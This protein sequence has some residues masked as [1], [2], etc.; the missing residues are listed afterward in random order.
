MKILDEQ[1]RFENKKEAYEFAY[2]IIMTHTVKHNENIEDKCDL[3]W[4]YK[5]VDDLCPLSLKM[6]LESAE[7]DDETNLKLSKIHHNI[8]IHEFY[9]PEERDLKY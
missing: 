6:M 9:C 2:L 5:S 7:K 1:F 8:G 3:K 4:F